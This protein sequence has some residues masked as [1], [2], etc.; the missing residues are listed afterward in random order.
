MAPILAN[1]I[2]IRALHI[3]EFP[4]GRFGYVGQVPTSIGFVDATPEKLEA[5]KYGARFGPRVR[6]FPTRQDGIDYAQKHG[7]E[8]A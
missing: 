2:P 5:R 7:Y 4:N 8:V 3:I 1:A 6:T